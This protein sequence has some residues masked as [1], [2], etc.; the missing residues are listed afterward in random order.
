MNT[1]SETRAGAGDNASEQ[2]TDIKGKVDQ[3]CARMENVGRK[4]RKKVK[5]NHCSKNENDSSSDMSTNIQQVLVSVTVEPNNSHD[6]PTTDESQNKEYQPS[7]SNAANTCVSKNLQICSNQKSS[8]ESN[9]CGLQVKV[10]PDCLASSPHHAI[11]IN[12]EPNGDAG[13]SSILSDLNT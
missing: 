1:S 2:T 12:S 8:E 9:N 3:L 4:I 13:E 11:S 5:T 6:D 10:V 7:S